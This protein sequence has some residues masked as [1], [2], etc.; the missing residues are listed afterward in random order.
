MTAARRGAFARLGRFTVRFRWPVLIG[1][2]VAL[3]VF[4]VLGAGV[5][6]SLKSEASWIPAASPARPPRPWRRS[7]QFE[8]R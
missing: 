7:S 4:G 1:Y 8:R 6:G 5:F 3:A 2:L